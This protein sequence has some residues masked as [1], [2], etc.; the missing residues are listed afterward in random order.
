MYLRTPVRPLEQRGAWPG[1]A[2]LWSCGVL[3]LGLS[4]PPGAQWLVRAA[5]QATGQRAGA[6]VTQAPA[7]PNH[8]E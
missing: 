1:L 6:P 8:A 5:R 3:T 7:P 2:T 4:I